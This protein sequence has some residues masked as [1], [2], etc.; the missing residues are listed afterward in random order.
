MTVRSALD[1]LDMDM[2]VVTLKR[3]IAC[4]GDNF[5]SAET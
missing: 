1:V 3:C 4:M 5:D 2:A